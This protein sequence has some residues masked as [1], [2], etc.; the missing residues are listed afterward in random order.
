MKNRKSMLKLFVLFA[1]IM[2]LI[3]AFPLQGLAYGEEQQLYISVNYTDAWG[4]VQQAQAQNIGYPGYEQAYWA[5]VP[6]DTDLSSLTLSVFDPTGTFFS[7]MPGDGETLQNVFDSR[8]NLETATPV[9]ITAYRADDYYG[10]QIV[11]YISTESG[12]PAPAESVS[13]PVYVNIHYISEEGY[14]ITSSTTQ[15]VYSEGYVPVYAQPNGLPEGYSLSGNDYQEVYADAQGNLDRSDVYFTYSYIPSVE[16]PRPV[17]VHYTDENGQP[18]ASDTTAYV[19][20]GDNFIDAQPY[21]LQENYVPVSED[22]QYVNA[23][24]EGNVYPTEVTFIYTYVV[25]VEWP[26]PVTVH[27][28]DE[29]GQPVASDTTAYAYEGDNSIDAQPYDLQENY[30]PASEGVQY[31]NAD[32][33]GNVYPTE[34]TFIYTY[35]APVEWPRPVTVHYCDEYNSPVADDTQVFINEGE[36]QVFPQPE[37]LKENY[38]LLSDEAV[39]VNAD[40]N[41]A[42]TPADEI[43]FVYTYVA[44]IEWPKYVTVHYISTEGMPVAEDTLFEIDQPG[45]FTIEPVPVELLVNY[46][47]SEYVISE[48]VTA[49]ESG[50]LDK[51]EVT[52]YY[53]YVSPVQWPQIVKVHYVSETGESIAPDSEAEVVEGSNTVNPNSEQLPENYVLVSEENVQ[54]TAISD[55]TLSQNEVTFVYAYV[56]P[57]TWPK[58]VIVHYQSVASEGETGNMVA[59]DTW[60]EVYAGDNE[61]RPEPTDLEP[62]FE[63]SGDESIVVYAD[64]SGNVSPSEVTFYYV[65]HEPVI[66]PQYVTVNY[67]SEEDSAPVAAK[68][69]R[70]VNPGENQIWAS[71]EGLADGYVLTGDECVT[72]YADADGNITPDTVTF[73]Y[74]YVQ[75]DTLWPV[76]IPVYHFYEESD[77]KIAED[78]VALISFGEN[79]IEPQQFDDYVSTEENVVVIGYEDGTLSQNEVIFQY[80]RNEPV[81][82]TEEIIIAPVSVS[83]IYRT[84]D[85]VKVA[86]TGTVVCNAGINPVYCAPVDLKDGYVLNDDEVKYV[87]VDLNGA[88]TYEVVFEYI[89]DTSEQYAGIP[90]AEPEV[91][92]AITPAPENTPEP[93][94]DVT[95]VR[96]EYVSADTGEV[97]YADNAP[98]VSGAST[99]IYA[100]LQKAQDLAGTNSNLVSDNPVIVSIDRDG[101]ST[102]EKVV[103]YFTSGK[104][105]VSVFYRDENGYDIAEPQQ[106]ECL[107]GENIIQ[108]NPEG[109]AEGYE[110]DYSKNE[111]TQSVTCVAG[112]LSPSSVIFYYRQT[113]AAVESMDT[114][115]QPLTDAVRVLS[116]PVMAGDKQIGTVTRRDVLHITEKI[117]DNSGEIWYKAECNGYAGYVHEDWIRFMSPD[118]IVSYLATPVPVIPDGPVSQSGSVI[119]LWGTASSQ[120]NFRQEP[121]T[122]SKRVESIDKGAKVWIMEEVDASEGDGKWYHAIFKNKEGYVSSKYIKLMT[123]EKSDEQ[124]AKLKSPAPEMFVY[125]TPAPTIVPTFTPVPTPEET[126]YIIATE[127]PATPAPTA[128]PERYIGY[129]LTNGEVM[130]RSDKVYADNVLSAATLVLITDQQWVDG[131]LWD[132]VDVQGRG[133]DGYIPDASTYHINDDEARY[134]LRNLQSTPVPT[135]A[136]QERTGFYRTAW[137]YTPCHAYPDEQ[138]YILDM[139]DENSTVYIIQQE[140]PGGIE[141][142]Y[143]QY[144][145]NYGYI[146]GDQLIEMSE[147]E[148][149]GY[150]SSLTTPTPS[151]IPSVPT[152]DPDPFSCYGF[153]QCGGVLNLRERPTQDSTPV[154][155]LNNYDLLM[156]IG[157]GFDNNGEEWYNV[158]VAEEDNSKTG[159]AKAEY[160][161]RLRTSQVDQFLNSAEYINA[162]TNVEPAQESNLY[163]YEDYNYSYVQPS[164]TALQTFAPY[165]PQNVY[166]PSQYNE[167]VEATTELFVTP[168]PDLPDHAP[169][170]AE[171]SET[172]SPYSQFAGVDDGT[173]T[174]DPGNSAPPVVNEEDTENNF[175]WLIVIGVVLIVGAAGAAYCYSIYVRNEKRRAAI[176]A[177]QARKQREASGTGAVGSTAAGR[178]TAVNAPKETGRTPGS[179]YGAATMDARPG[180]SGVTAQNAAGVYTRPQTSSQRPVQ[181]AAPAGKPAETI[182]MTSVPK[183]SPVSNGTGI[184]EMPGNSI[185]TFT[186]SAGN[187]AAKNSPISNAQQN[188]PSVR[189]RRSDTFKD[190]EV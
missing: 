111:N 167:P 179:S 174:N 48:T 138:G 46:E 129:A 38:F 61:I 52:F 12:V 45:S 134:Y 110:L 147:D 1:M 20:E 184:S 97:F 149:Q 47:L 34:V 127:P 49:D 125:T 148:I 65:Y 144:G 92:P 2:S 66:W 117:T 77:Q 19:S 67:V 188:A 14:E 190:D 7:F 95:L 150:F 172:I 5:Q 51:T 126:P 3:M 153:V 124:Q 86:S 40:S 96:I 93:V 17:I 151:P 43:T 89:P 11:L 137:P 76:S 26:R 81:L 120:V 108:A 164:G 69:S 59:T 128:V 74:R 176:R 104:T 73:T 178:P 136:P 32:H 106:V 37:N 112:M 139:L 85:G 30:V 27:Y 56:E 25:P 36:T 163:S 141:W 62:F 102:P 90:T 157:S 100:D 116:E 35:V 145:N 57:V 88:D 39:K 156:I 181:S 133:I 101:H 173:I 180:Q 114:Y 15:E 160:V 118:E 135:P 31:V 171:P 68:Q 79:I 166:Y 146:R 82:P 159:Y 122:G 54:I 187:P 143:V 71:P 9:M 70:E 107:E 165:Q 189:K 170:T 131:E 103:F 113:K 152:P 8:S 41:G 64:K 78:T 6:Y 154:T 158:I 94:P 123:K 177:Q 155:L 142:D 13:W 28:T 99:E 98:C 83:V 18:V 80:Y 21:D 75:T 169:T 105:T 121:S 162:H 91:T 42:V 55:G 22:T 132:V 24:H 44:P 23:D 182:R 29:N 185:P 50:N 60:A 119:N 63:L 33:E 140:F 53:E 10:T 58:N 72:V 115:A 175:P 168:T 130:L 84:A 161:Q 16:W 4:M 183:A 109:L 186:Q 87:T